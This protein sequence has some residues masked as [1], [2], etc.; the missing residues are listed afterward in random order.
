[1]YLSLSFSYSLGECAIPTSFSPFMSNSH[2]ASKYFIPDN[3]SSSLL[4]TTRQFGLRSVPNSGASN[5]L[6]MDSKRTMRFPM[7][8][9]HST[10]AWNCLTSFLSNTTGLSLLMM[11]QTGSNRSFQF[12]Q[13][14]IRIGR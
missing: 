2:V 11:L 3:R 6:S 5:T 13:Q 14:S 4:Y 7:V 10:S 12:G 9:G 1:M 8:D